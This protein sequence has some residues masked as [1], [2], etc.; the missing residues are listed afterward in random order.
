MMRV[1]KW[2]ASSDRRNI[3]MKAAVHGGFIPSTDVVNIRTVGLLG[4]DE[5]GKQIIDGLL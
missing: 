3:L 2:A 4:A 1:F 5:E